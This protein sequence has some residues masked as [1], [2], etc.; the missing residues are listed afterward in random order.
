MG[1]VFFLKNNYTEARKYYE[2]AFAKDKNDPAVLLNL[3]KLSYE[4][5]KYDRTETY[6]SMLK[7]QDK[8][9]AARY[10]YLAM[11]GEAGNARAAQA[12]AMKGV[13]EWGE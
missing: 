8:S 4:E 9:L 7:K 11:K 1:N 2:R 5:G 13:V 12:D 6:Y 10:E 3:A